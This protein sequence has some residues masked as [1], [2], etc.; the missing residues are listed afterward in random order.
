VEARVTTQVLVRRTVL[1]NDQQ[2]HTWGYLEDTLDLP[3]FS[4]RGTLKVGAAH[5][6]SFEGVE[7]PAGKVE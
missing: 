2:A 3:S 5:D 1:S 6:R 4:G 7:I